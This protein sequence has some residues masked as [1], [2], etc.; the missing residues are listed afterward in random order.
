MY[1]FTDKS[2]CGTSYKLPVGDTIILTL[3]TYE[4][5]NTVQLCGHWALAL[6]YR[7]IMK[8]VHR[9]LW[10]P[11]QQFSYFNC[12]G[13]SDNEGQ[14]GEFVSICFN[15]MLAGPSAGWSRVRGL[16]LGRGRKCGSGLVVVTVVRPPHVVTTSVALLHFILEL[17]H[18]N[19][20]TATMAF[21]P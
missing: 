19:I 3:L 1:N 15:Y 17:L 4:G 8:K 6:H 16:S 13:R 20:D 7:L 12:F 18:F 2:I 11:S 21:L 10:A 9:N 14:F 5:I